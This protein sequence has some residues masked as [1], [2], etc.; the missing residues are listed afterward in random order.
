MTGRS[1]DP[2]RSTPP[3]GSRAGTARRTARLFVAAGVGAGSAAAGQ[4]LFGGDAWWLLL[5]AAVAAGWWRVA[6]PGACE[7]PRR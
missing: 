6:D 1:E 3:A 2:W 5:P 7:P 4:A